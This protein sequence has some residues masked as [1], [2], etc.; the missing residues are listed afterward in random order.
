MGTLGDRCMSRLLQ[1]TVLQFILDLVVAVGCSG[2]P[3]RVE[4]DMSRLVR[5]MERSAQLDLVSCLVEARR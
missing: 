1:I 2:V 5:L 4:I 3:L